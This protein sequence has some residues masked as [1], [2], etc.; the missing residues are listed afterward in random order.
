M[1]YRAATDALIKPG[2]RA[3][4]DDTWHALE[5]VRKD[6]R[7]NVSV[8]GKLEF[9]LEDPRHRRRVSPAFHLLGEGAELR[10]KALKI[11]P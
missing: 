2:N 4:G 8:D 11:E 7:V 1:D 10:V 3:L 5:V 6:G 9:D